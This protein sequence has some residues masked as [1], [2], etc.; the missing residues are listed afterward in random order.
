MP[1]VTVYIRK[2]D[3]DKWRALEKKSEFIH[4]ALDSTNT[5]AVG[6]I[7]NSNPKLEVVRIEDVKGA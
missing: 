5:P 3:L 1:Q 6:Q 4:N 7:L 2:D